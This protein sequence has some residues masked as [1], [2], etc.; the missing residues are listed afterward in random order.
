MFNLYEFEKRVRSEEEQLLNTLREE[1]VQRSQRSTFR[2]IST[3]I[4]IER[5]EEMSKNY[6]K[7]VAHF[8]QKVRFLLKH[9]AADDCGYRA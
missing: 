7:R 2:L 4:L 5:N 1:K 9:G 6:K 3:M 8:I